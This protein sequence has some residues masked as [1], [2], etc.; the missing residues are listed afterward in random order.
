MKVNM[1]AATTES[2]YLTMKLLS[3]KNNPKDSFVNEVMP[4]GEEDF[5]DA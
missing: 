1:R 4:S 2:R 3:N 5:L